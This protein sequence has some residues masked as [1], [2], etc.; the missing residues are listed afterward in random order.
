MERG[1]KWRSSRT[2]L[3][4]APR[5]SLGSR[6]STGEKPGDP[7]LT[8]GFSFPLL[9][10]MQPLLIWML[11]KLPEIKLRVQCCGPSLG[12]GSDTTVGSWRYRHM[13]G[14]NADGQKLQL[15]C[16]VET[17]QNVYKYVTLEVCLP[18]YAY[19]S[20]ILK[21]YPENI[22]Y[23][24]LTLVIVYQT[25]IHLHLWGF[26]KLSC[27]ALSAFSTE[28]ILVWMRS[29]NICRHTNYFQKSE[30]PALN[31]SNVICI[32]QE[33]LSSQLYDANIC[34]IGLIQTY[35]LH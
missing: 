35:K 33:I 34:V 29:Q 15:I 1:R 21:G 25:A 6:Q 31:L 4:W 12:T 3:L 14:K 28:N 10:H 18:F 20:A 2:G 30:T 32:C 26:T 17:P 13:G 24:C 5:A 27:P 19:Y 9:L 23:V 22:R 7:R 11:R 8:S 16:L